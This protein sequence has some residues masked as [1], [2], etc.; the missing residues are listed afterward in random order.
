MEDGEVEPGNSNSHCCLSLQLV[1]KCKW[2]A[3]Y[4]R[5]VSQSASHSEVNLYHRCTWP[6]GTSNLRSRS[7]CQVQV[8]MTLNIVWHSQLKPE[9]RNSCGCSSEGSSWYHSDSHTLALVMEQVKD[10]SVTKL[11]SNCFQEKKDSCFWHLALSP[12][13][14]RP[15]RGHPTIAMLA[16]SAFSHT[17]RGSR[18]NKPRDISAL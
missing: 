4:K 15:Q 5:E 16:L 14:H 1:H 12:C 11:V 10:L 18:T 2:I 3:S 8:A 7:S 9:L 13:F 6:W 17:L